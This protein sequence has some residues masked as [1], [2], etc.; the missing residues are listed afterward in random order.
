MRVAHH[1]GHRHGLSERAPEP[2]DGEEPLA[3]QLAQQT[4]RL[5]IELPSGTTLE[6]IAEDENRP[7]LYKSFARDFFDQIIVDECHRGSAKDD[8]LW[9]SILD[10]YGSA[11]Q[12]G[13]LKKLLKLPKH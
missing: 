10:Y 8:G 7:G 6:S 11:T 4:G 2:E 5:V 9:R 12:I 13:Q 3:W 1:E